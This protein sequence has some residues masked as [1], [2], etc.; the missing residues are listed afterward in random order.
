[1]SAVEK[2]LS[3]NPFA[4]PEDA[5]EA[6]DRRQFVNLF[7]RTWPYLRPQLPHLA[8]WISAR[9]AVELIFIFAALVAY[10]LFNNKILLGEKLEAGQAALLW[11]DESYVGVPEVLQTPESTG[12]GETD[13]TEPAGEID[14]P[15][16]AFDPATM[17]SPEQRRTVTNR[18]GVLFAIIAVLMFMLLPAADYYGTWI[19]QRVNQFLRVTMVERAEHLSLRYHSHARTGDAIYRVFQDSAM[20]TSVIERVLI[21]PVVAIGQVLFS[22]A[23]ICLFSRTLGVLYL[24]GVVPVVWLLVWF[25]PRLQV[26]SR[27]AR[28]TNGALVS[29]IQESFAA[30]RVVKANRAEGVVWRRFD[31]DSRSALDAAFCLRTEYIVMRTLVAL[32]AGILLIAAQVLMAGWTIAEDPTFLAGAV[33]LVG[34][35]AWNLG[36][37]DAAYS[38]G[39]EMVDNGTDLTRI[40]GLLQDMAAGLERAFTLLELKP[41][42]VDKPNAVPLPEA[43]REVQF[44]DVYF[45]YDAGQP[46]L[47]GVDLRAA[48]GTVTAI[49]GG[50]GAGKSTLMSLLLRLYDPD[51]GVIRINGTPLDDFQVDSLRAGVAIALQQNVL[52]TAT[53]ADNIAYATAHATRQDIQNAAQIACAHEFIETM[54]EGYDSELGERGSKLSTG[55]RQRLSI[56]RAVLRD[57]PILILDEPTASLDAATEQA[58]LASLAAWAEHRVVFLITH[59]LSTIRNADQIALL[60]DGVVR[61]FGTHDALIAMNGRYRRFVEAETHSSDAA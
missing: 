42:I 27:L 48:A 41:D 28:A 33:A 36:A 29:R 61:E 57:T 25:A 2:P 44:E 38:R 20:I 6:L 3:T 5:G 35:T 53:V 37:F 59:R 26:R 47:Q 10:D 45:G 18:L 22:F 31:D 12:G 50:T 14:E 51:R 8:T 16:G 7:G 43:V 13:A 23:V 34:F 54:P 52:F 1:M 30:I 4:L 32:V 56:A 21:E 19:L 24:A 15:A 60:E 40:W 39:E 11:L 17:L 9:M 55:Q 58:V 46:V 49:V